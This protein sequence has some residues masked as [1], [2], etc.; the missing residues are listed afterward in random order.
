MFVARVADYRGESLCVHGGKKAEDGR[1]TEARKTKPAEEQRL[2]VYWAPE[3]MEGA[4]T[5]L[6]VTVT[7]S[8]APHIAFFLPAPFPSQ[9]H[10]THPESIR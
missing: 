9:M 4:V 10:R 1:S 7:E 8:G 2:D 6:D 3:R 5:L